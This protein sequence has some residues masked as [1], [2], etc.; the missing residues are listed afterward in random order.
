MHNKLK[1]KMSSFFFQN[2]SKASYECISKVPGKEEVYYREGKLVVVIEDTEVGKRIFPIIKSLIDWDVRIFANYFEFQVG[3]YIADKSDTVQMFFVDFYSGFPYTWKNATALN[4][5][6]ALVSFTYAMEEKGYYLD[7]QVFNNETCHNISDFLS[8]FSPNASEVEKS[9]ACLIKYIHYKLSH[10]G[11]LEE[12]YGDIIKKNAITQ[13]SSFPYR[14][15]IIQMCYHYYIDGFIPTNI[16]TVLEYV[17]EYEKN[18]I[19]KK[20]KEKNA[21]HYLLVSNPNLSKQYYSITEE[22]EEYTVYNGTIKIFKKPIS[23]GLKQLLQ[24]NKKQFLEKYSHCFYSY[25]IYEKLNSIVREVL[26]NTILDFDGNI[27]GYQYS[28][29]A[30]TNEQPIL[31]SQFEFQSDIIQFVSQLNKALVKFASSDNL[32]ASSEEVKHEIFNV[33]TDVIYSKEGMNFI[34]DSIRIRTIQDLQKLQETNVSIIHEEITMLFFKLLRTYLERKYGTLSSIKL[35]L[36][37]KEVRYLSPV[38]AKQFANFVVG[39]PINLPKATQAL[40][41]FLSYDMATTNDRVAYDNRILYKPDSKDSFLFQ[42]EVESK[43]GIKFQKGKEVTLFDG[44]KIV[45][46]SHPKNISKVF[47]KIQET[48]EEILEK[49]GMIESKDVKLNNISEFIYSSNLDSEDL[50]LVAGYISKPVC[51]V[52]LTCDLLLTFSNKQIL[53]VA[54]KLIAK[55]GQYYLNSVFINID[56]KSDDFT[57]YID[58]LDSGFAIKKT[59]IKQATDYVQQ[60]IEIVEHFFDYLEQRG[61]NPNAFTSLDLR[62]MSSIIELLD[63]ANSLDTYCD[64]HK[65]YYAHHKNMCPICMRTRRMIEPNFE[66]RYERIFEDEYAV[67]Y[68]YDDSYN[69]KIY[70]DNIAMLDCLEKNVDTI[71]L[72]KLKGR[73]LKMK[74]DCFIPERKAL[75]ENNQFIGYLYSAIDFKDKDCKNLKEVESFENLPKIKSLIRLIGQVE[76]LILDGYTF[77]RNPFGDVFLCVNHKKQ[78]QIVNI[79]F[80]SKEKAPRFQQE[81]KRE[82]S[83]KWLYQYVRT[84]IASDSN[85]EL[86]CNDIKNKNIVLHLEHLAQDLTMYCTIHK[87]Y[88]HSEDVFCPKCIDISNTQK[89]KKEC[90]DSSEI[91][92]WKHLKPGGESNIYLRKDGSVA[93]VF[94]EKV[95][96][97]FKIQI[98]GA[99]FRKKEILEQIN[100]ETNAFK[101]IIPQKILID[102]MTNHVIGY[103]MKE[104]VKGV[105]IS[106]LKDTEKVQNK[107]GYTQKDIFEIL[108]TVG[109]GIQ[110]L[111]DRANIYIGDLNGG[112]ILI[113]AQKNV[114][115]L[116]FDGM[117]IDNIAPRFS[118]EGYIDPVSQKANHITP[119]DDWYSFAIQA[120]YYLTYTHPFNGV[121]K[122]KNRMLEI[123]E[124]MER[125]LSLL[126]NHGITPPS[127]AKPW[128]WMNLDL[129]N[130]FLNIFE[131]DSRKSIVPELKKQYH[132]LF[133]GNSLETEEEIIRI[134]NKFV[135]K[136]NY[137]YDTGDNDIVRVINHYTTINSS[138]DKYYVFMLLDGEIHKLYIP[139]C[140]QIMDIFWLKYVAIVVY[141]DRIVAFDYETDGEVF[142]ENYD[143]ESDII[144]VNDNT[145]Y[146]SQN[147]DSESRIYEIDF[148]K[149]AKAKKSKISFLPE[150]KTVG[151]LVKFNSKFMLIKRDSN[152]K[153]TIYCNSEKLCNIESD[154]QNSKYRILYDKTTRLWV[155]ISSHKTIITVESSNSQYKLWYL[156]IEEDDIDVQNA[157]VDKGF[158][159]LPGKGVLYIVNLKKEMTIKRLEC[160]KLITPDSRLCDFNPDGFSIITNYSLYD[161]LKEKIN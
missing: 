95:D 111:H 38:L 149:K 66:Q 10:G 132:E 16:E 40:Y 17:L 159:Y 27:I 157:T 129:R 119:K 79:E 29:D 30:L 103:I 55:F 148:N 127:I 52:P 112:N 7:C 98:L 138:G 94:N 144:V 121:Y 154:S 39:R 26:E 43:Y 80:L 107:L 70:K 85:I 123:P 42:Y 51:G 90:V 115:F 120:F 56:E 65:I 46:F 32:C 160:D 140:L 105:A 102:K 68:K 114:H 142:K 125:R 37:K 93:K 63:Y 50:Y 24:D 59:S 3:G 20:E 67:H 137:L 35:I 152:G 145:L 22:N 139:D 73:E 150:Q 69:L 47:Q 36:S 23:S 117:G 11:N 118:T 153:D 113:D 57:F 4:Q 133:E 156:S 61:Y 116:D 146:L 49:I 76:L 82:E 88:Y 130:A 21:E 99:I 89:I 135:A 151:F 34:R 14:M 91:A 8:F 158:L 64:E 101:F 104:K 9:N 122:E 108:I 106:T 131:G 71:I 92:T 87:Y 12:F 48:E 126:G 147:S 41:H 25:L 72:M 100:E 1:N 141:Q 96:Y 86:D 78:V 58:T 19:I 45:M 124:K 110:T 109:E 13:L 5:L 62:G 75:N 28:L 77:D 134:N 97:S 18:A 161:I 155:V 2:F 6:R 83:I 143:K 33:E 84:I 44:R 74:Q 31:E 136:R 53:Q 15:P 81:K 128:Y 60:E 54:G